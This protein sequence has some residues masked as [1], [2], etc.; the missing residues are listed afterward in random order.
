MGIPFP[1]FFAW[2]VAIVEFVGGFFLIIGFA[3]RTI[4][5]FMAIT[6]VVAITKAKIGMMKVPFIAK[7]ATG[8][9]FDFS[10][11]GATLALFFVGPGNLAFHFGLGL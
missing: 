9:E 2:V 7:E 3:T 11:L 6:M 10:L 8:W 5:L 1:L 4:A